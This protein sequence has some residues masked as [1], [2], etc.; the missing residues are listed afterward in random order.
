MNVTGDRLRELRNEKGKTL[1]EMAQATGLKASAISNYENGI[2]IPRR[3]AMDILTD[4]FN[5]D[6]D[7]ILGKSDVRNLYNFEG[8]YRKGYEEAV[9]VM[10]SNAKVP[11][12]DPLSCGNGTWVE[13]TPEDIISIPNYL[14]GGGDYFANPALGDSME[15]RIKP[16]DL[17]I[18]EKSSF[19]DSGQIGSFALNGEY[20]CKRFKEFP[21]GSMWLMSEN[22]QY[23]PIKIEP[24]DKFDVLGVYRIKISKEQ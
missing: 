17:L 19:I 2:R 22:P 11:V 4:Y 3:E 6:T 8:I 10:D 21:D 24:D 13:E 23:D 12:Y 14:V 9:K 18:F 5:V 20:Y 15:P 1:A 16:G 7:Y